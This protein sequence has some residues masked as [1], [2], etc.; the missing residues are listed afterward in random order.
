MKRTIAKITNKGIYRVIYDTE[1][2]YNPYTVYVERVES[3]GRHRRKVAEYA[4]L[5]SCLYYIAEA[6]K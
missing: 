5:E 6:C 1:A 3:D 4:D 2:K